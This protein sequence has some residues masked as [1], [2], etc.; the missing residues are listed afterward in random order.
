M[1]SRRFG[2]GRGAGHGRGL[3]GA[4]FRG[5][6]SRLSLGRPPQSARAAAHSSDSA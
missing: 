5:R 1:D 6:A 2:Q 4:R 3:G